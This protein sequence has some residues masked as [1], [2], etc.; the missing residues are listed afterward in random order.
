MAALWSTHRMKALAALLDRSHPPPPER[1]VEVGVAAGGSEQWRRRFL[2]P[3]AEDVHQGRSGRPVDDRHRDGRRATS[4]PDRDRRPLATTVPVAPAPLP[5]PPL[6]PA[7][8][9]AADVLHVKGGGGELLATRGGQKA[10]ARGAPAIE[11]LLATLP[12][13]LA[14]RVRAGKK[15]VRLSVE[16][17]PLGRAYAIA[18]LRPAKG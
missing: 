6:E 4:G 14:A 10:V 5:P 15:S 18:A 12:E 9:E 11:A 3:P 8:W 16:V 1:V 7:T 17:T 2:L 13:D